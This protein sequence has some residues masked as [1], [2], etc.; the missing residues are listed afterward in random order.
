M[1][2]FFK[3]KYDPEN[4]KKLRGFTFKNIYEGWFIEVCQ[5]KHLPY[6]AKGM[7]VHLSNEDEHKC[8]DVVKSRNIVED[9]LCV[10]Y[11]QETTPTY[12][13]LI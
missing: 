13:I 6:L 1:Y 9:V 7:K 5:L 11:S 12:L 10:I 2:R 8:E 4:P 3:R